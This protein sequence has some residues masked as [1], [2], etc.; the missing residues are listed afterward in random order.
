MNR[1]MKSSLSAQLLT[2]GVVLLAL[3]FSAPELGLARSSREVTPEEEARLAEIR[4]YIERNGYHW[5]ADHT[6]VSGLSEEEK[7]WRKGFVMT[8]EIE[9]DMASVVVDPAVERMT[10]RSSYDWR[11][12]DG[13]TPAKDQL[14]CGSCWAFA[15]A[16]AVEAHIRI[17]EGVLLDISEQQ[18]IDCNGVGSGC[19]GGTCTVGFSVY[20]D[21]GA[22]S[23]E[24]YPY[25]AEDSN[26]RQ[27]TCDVVGLIDSYVFIANTVNSIK[28]AV[29]TYGP[30][31]TSIHVYDDLFSYS[32]GCYEHPGNDFTDHTVLICGWDDDLC[33]GEGAWL[34]KNS[35]GQD[36]GDNGFGWMKYGTCRIGSACYRP[37]NAH[38]PHERFVPD[39]YSTIQLALDNSNRGDIIKVA[40]GTYPGSVTVPTYVQMYGGYDPT[41]TVRDPE[42][43]PTVIDANQGGHGLN[44]SER[45]YIVVDGFEVEDAG[46]TGYYGIYLKNSEAVVRNCVVRNSWRGIGVVQGMGE[47]A[48]TDAVIEY[49]KVYDNDSEGIYVSNADNPAVRIRYTAIYGNG[50]EGVYSSGSP[51]EITQCTITANGSS[52]GIEL[53]SSSGNIVTNNIITS[54]TGYG[55]TCSSASPVI[56]YSDVWGNSSGDYDGCSSGTGCISDDPEFCDP[57]ASDYTVYAGS[58]T[59]GTG[60]YGF[61]MGALGIG[62]PI[63]P[64][65]LTVT[66]NGASLELQWSVPPPSRAD[67]DYYIVYRDTTQI[68][69]TEI[70]TVEAPDT[71]FTDTTI[72]P[73]VPYNYW[74]SAVD[75]GGLEGAPSDKSSGEICYAGP[76]DVDVAFVEGANEISWSHG[77]GPIAR[78]DIYRSSES[79]TADSVGSVSQ[80]ESFFVDDTSDDCPRDK[81]GYEVLPIYDTGWVGIVSEKVI[82]DPLISPPSGI[83]LEWVSDDILVTWQPNCESDFRRYWVY[84]DTIPIAPP[85][86]FNLL[87]GT[88]TDTFFVDE[89][90]DPGEVYFY[91]LTASD[92]SQ[93][94]STY[95][96]MAWMGSGNVLQV[97]TPYGT[98][99]AAINAAAALDTVLVAPGTYYENIDL[100]DG[101][102]VMSSG[103]R[104]TTTITSSASPVIDALSLSDLAVLEGFTID[105]QGAAYGIETWDS[106]IVVED[107]AI[108]NC[109][110]GMSMQYGG[111]PRLN[112]NLITANQTG[113]AVSDSSAPFLSGNT[114]DGNSFAAISS[115]GSVG[116]EIGR[117]LSDANDFI[118][119]GLIYVLNTGT[120]TVDADYNWWGDV[121]PE[122][123]WFSGA[124]DYVPW[125][126]ESHT[127]IYMGCTGIPDG[128]ASK[129]L[130]SYN[131]PN[132]FNPST[133]IQYRVPDRG[134]QVRLRIY[135][136]RG[137]LV[138]TLVSEPKRGGDYLAV[139]HGRD[140]TGRE[141]GSG[142]YFYRLEIGRETF[143]R[144]MVMLK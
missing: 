138:R 78:Y 135:D 95:S 82:I 18:A 84:R 67:V 72:P 127:E 63:G 123:T 90:L 34:V 52:G 103:G 16:G 49:C 140:D 6:S 86:D 32:G 79:S 44:I 105:G 87:T 14:D 99:Q 113:V 26:C 58:P 23:E 81:Y 66:Q 98:I 45:D 126:D 110:R 4:D 101:I 96:E 41:F 73:C 24:C 3:L 53:N 131:Y 102:H 33:G 47:P 64:Q 142:V 91:R 12:Y 56:T 61:N 10:F 40:G 119:M 109:T 43:Y 19:D 85:V 108:Q 39:E 139:W 129:P 38:V 25:L 68:P 59:V 88:S 27:G 133:T 65:N 51:T 5:T 21:P 93:D 124:V 48:E 144:K 74:V 125:T 128:D 11:D 30:V 37:T 42:Q 69:L 1:I 54:N 92:A 114:F 120:A 118:N 121:C 70:A 2:V 22:V 117:T 122:E 9:A 112:G 60:Q 15:S 8:P 89:S 83:S 94:Q 71:T 13:V 107:C 137:R 77:A 130:A 76:T 7:E 136:L 97:P 57:G 75:L 143:Q 106:Y 28:S 17:N 80:S 55:V 46:G 50:A 35:W 116:P 62:C 134:G 132:P 111:A 20:R 141:M 29:Q 100:K 36:W 31:V 115:G 104:A